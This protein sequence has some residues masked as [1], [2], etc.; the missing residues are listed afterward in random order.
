MLKKLFSLL[1]LSIFIGISTAQPP[2]NSAKKIDDILSAMGVTRTTSSTGYYTE[3]SPDAQHINTY[4]ANHECTDSQ[5]ISAHMIKI[6]NKKNATPTEQEKADFFCYRLGTKIKIEQAPKKISKPTM[7]KEFIKFNTFAIPRLL[8]F[9][10]IPKMS[11]YLPTFT[12]LTQE[13]NKELNKLLTLLICTNLVDFAFKNFIYSEKQDKKE[14]NQRASYHY[15]KHSKNSSLPE[16]INSPLCKKAFDEG[17][18]AKKAI[19]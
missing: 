14:L 5:P 11:S 13:N 1:T 18:K 17:R 19:S 10:L 4:N 8:L 16:E 7:I 3:V 2:T 9:N 12:K 15:G 6:L